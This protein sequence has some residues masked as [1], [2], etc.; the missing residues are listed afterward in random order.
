MVVFA[1]GC[2][3]QC[4]GCH[5]PET[6]PFGAGEEYSV[7]DILNIASKNP[8][9]D[10]L[11]LSG[12]EPFCQ[13]EGFAQL[14]K[15]ASER[16]LSVWTYSGYTFEELLASGCAHTLALLRYT[17]ILVDG[18]FEQDLIINPKPFT[19]SSNQRIIDTNKSLREGKAVEFFL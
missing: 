4:K 10:G 2:P 16:G 14:A 12:G 17:D 15:G 1:Q 7:S 19:G 5:N 8:L 6:H 18:R 13:A 3:H 11:T 9:L